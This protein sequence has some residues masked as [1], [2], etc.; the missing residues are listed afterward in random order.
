MQGLGEV[1]GTTAGEGIRV[2]DDEIAALPI[3]RHRFHGDW[4]Y[5][6]HPQQPMDTTP[7]AHQARPWRTDRLASR[8]V[9]F[10]TR[11]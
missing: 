1:A 10:R 9:H 7:A 4:N 5:T 3:T 2:S 6:L 11:N 8:G